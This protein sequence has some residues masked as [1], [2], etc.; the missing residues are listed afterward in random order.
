M[1]REE[2]SR[3]RPP[4]DSEPHQEFL[5]LCSLF[6]SGLLSEEERRR[7]SQ[8]L[9]GCAVCRQARDE[10]QVVV[11]RAIPALAA[12][13]LPDVE[14]GPSW[15][16]KR[17]E[18]AL[19]ARIAREQGQERDGRKIQQSSE[20]GAEVHL[21]PALAGRPTWQR[22]WAPYA[23]AVVLL[24]ALGFSTYRVGVHRGSAG[25]M[26]LPSAT[27]APGQ[28]ALQ[29]QLSDAGHER[30]M[31][32]AQIAQREQQIAEQRGQLQRQKAEMSKIQLAQSR[33]K[34]QL[35]TQEQDRQDVQGQ[36]TE[37]AQKLAAAQAA[38]QSLERQLVTLEQRTS[39]D[40]QRA[41]TLETKVNVLTQA[42]VERD[43]TVE[44]QQKLLAHDRDIRELM[45]ARDLYV[46]EVYDVARAGKTRQ[47]YGRVF[48]TKGRSLV[49][50]AYDLEQQTALKNAS[51]FQ[52]WGRRGA[53][54]K[55]PLNLGIFYVD[56][57]ANK[58]WV[59]KVD[60]PKA[61][62]QIDAV[63]VTVEPHGGSRRP[64]G[65]S[66]LF[67]YLRADPNHP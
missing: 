65:K 15:W 26:A 47:P 53:D 19:F 1:I 18:A 41:K 50:Y 33:L 24:I 29:A 7:L 27:S 16:E 60:D 6:A 14:P 55:Q 11:D 62:A 35:R 46:A 63:F 51:S 56:N 13:E 10:C 30:E 36:R 57:A 43:V 5:E 52:A 32:R 58:R 61:L 12:Q 25:A 17:A 20:L 48:F 66:L 28:L 45:G 23:V 67:A 34:D 37:L 38:S 42:L 31:V 39:E 44:Q 3:M 2:D 54:P 4:N 22:V 59:L 21:V 49:F 64:S 40:A 9:A 8:H